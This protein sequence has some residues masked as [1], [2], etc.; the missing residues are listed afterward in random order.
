MIA[1]VLLFYSAS[2]YKAGDDT[3]SRAQVME[4]VGTWLGIGCVFLLVVALVAYGHYGSVL[5]ASAARLDALSALGCNGL[6]ESTEICVRSALSG[7]DEVSY[8]ASAC[9]W[10]SFSMIALVI[11]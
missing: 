6:G 8:A 1:L 7:V 11:L 2:L 9:S 10:I 4:T 3:L 5:D